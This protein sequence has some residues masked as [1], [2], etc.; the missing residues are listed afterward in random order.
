MKEHIF[1]YKTVIQRDNILLG[2]KDAYICLYGI[3]K[4]WNCQKKKYKKRIRNI[5]IQIHTVNKQKAKRINKR[6]IS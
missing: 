6:Y 3:H 2:M 1:A 4:Q 5:E